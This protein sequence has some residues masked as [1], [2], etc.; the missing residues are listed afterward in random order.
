MAGASQSP[1]VQ[2]VLCFDGT[3]NTFEVNGTDTNILKICGMLPRSDN[4]CELGY[5]NIVSA[6]KI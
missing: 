6:S 2:I 1:P 4:Q 5:F 3:G